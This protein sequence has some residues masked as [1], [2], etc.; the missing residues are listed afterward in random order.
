MSFTET[1]NLE[2]RR[3]LAERLLRDEDREAIQLEV[4]VESPNKSR[5]ER[6][7]AYC[8]ARK[9]GCKTEQ[10]NAPVK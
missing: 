4:I 5:G 1:G 8:T 2:R 6:A 9:K 10:S 3:Y 7:G